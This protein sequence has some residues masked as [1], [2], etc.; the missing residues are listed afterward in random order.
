VGTG[1]Q[2]EETLWNLKNVKKLDKQKHLGSPKEEESL[3]I[4]GWEKRG[5]PGNQ[6]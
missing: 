6:Y 2:R 5:E 1:T 3:K 4:R